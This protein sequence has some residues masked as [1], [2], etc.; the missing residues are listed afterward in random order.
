MPATKIEAKLLR[1][2]EADLTAE[3]KKKLPRVLRTCE[4]I[5]GR[6]NVSVHSLHG[7]IGGKNNEYTDAIRTQFSSPDDFNARWL[8]GLRRRAERAVLY[9]NAAT[10]IAR[11]MQSKVIR[12]YNAHIPDSQFLSQH[13]SN[14]QDRSPK[15]TTCGDCGS[16][17]TRLPWGL[18]IAP[19]YRN[20]EWT[21]DK[22]EIRRAKY[23][24]WTVGHVLETGIID[25]E[26]DELLQ[27]DTIV[28]IK[29]FY[30]SVL[31]RCSASRYE[32]ELA[33]RYVQY[34][35]DSDDVESEPFLIPELRY[36]GLQ[37]KHKYRLDFTMLNPHMMTF[38]GFEISPA[39]THMSVKGTKK[40]MQRSVNA[41]LKK[42]WEKEMKK[43]NR[44]FKDFGITT[45]T[46][47]DD[48]LADIDECFEEMET[49]LSERPDEP[50]SLEYQIEAL[51]SL[52]L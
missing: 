16:A 22:S 4:R 13:L 42:K 8:Q 44:Y 27:F 19:V 3:L 14:A 33:K 17:I 30:Q 50:V 10:R 20:D 2:M 21:N 47:T 24:Y 46:F 43:R 36:A 18:F 45:I 5:T 15:T 1:E 39:S 35:R 37:A 41:E 38:V 12:D 34:L 51:K 52:D 7:I 9:E 25:P 48:D 28:S 26:S 23:D 32:R 49:Y 31:R 40:K 6:K 29:Q 11:L